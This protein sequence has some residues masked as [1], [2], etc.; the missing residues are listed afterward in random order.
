[1][2]GASLSHKG[3]IMTSVSLYERVRPATL[4]DVLGQAKAVA[5]ARRMIAA[6]VG[7]RAIWISGPSG[8][9]KTTLARIIARSIADD[10]AIDEYDC[11]DQ[12]GVAELRDIDARIRYYGMG[13]G[14]RAIIVNESHGLRSV[15]IRFLLGLLERIPPHVVF[16]FTTTKAG[17]ESLFGD[18][19]D[20][21]PLLSRCSAI[22]LTNQGLADALAPRLRDI[23]QREQLDGAPVDAYKK[24]M[25]RCKNNIRAA[26]CAIDA[27]EMLAE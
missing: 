11:A 23:A 7:G 1:V 3:I 8:A 6:G 4:D 24:L 13:R 9:G 17:Q 22:T 12:L 2:L 10:A 21:G 15:S 25:Q 19:I 27:G 26:L 14:G 18:E 16:I 5:I 20:A